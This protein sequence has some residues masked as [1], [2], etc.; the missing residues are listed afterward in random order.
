M[1]EN[2]VAW[3]T[4]F[5][6]DL[7]LAGTSELLSSDGGALAVR[8]YLERT[9]LVRTLA[10]DVRDP[11]QPDLVTRSMEELLLTRLV[12]ICQGWND[13]DDADALRADPGLVHAVGGAALTEGL[14]SQP[15]LSR[16][17]ACLGGNREALSRSLVRSAMQQLDGAEAADGVIVD[18]DS[19]PIVVHGHQDGAEYNGHY[20]DIVFHPLVASIGARRLLLSVQLRPGAVHTATGVEQFT[21]DLL[22]ALREQGLRVN[23]LRFDAGFVAPEYLSRLEAAGIH[24]V[25]RI[26][27]NKV[28]NEMASSLMDEMKL[29]PR[30]DASET[31][32]WCIESTYCAGSW[33]EARRAVL[34]AEHEPSEL[35]VNHF[36]V[37]TSLPKA[38][39]SGPDLLSTYRGRGTAESAFGEFKSVI[40]PRLAHFAETRDKSDSPIRVAFERNEAELLLCAIAFNVLNALRELAQRA[41]GRALSLRTVRERVLKVAVRIVHH[42][43]TVRVT[44]ARAAESVWCALWMT[45]LPLVRG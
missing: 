25:A 36:W 8:E 34:M 32:T 35:F 38:K 15:T 39:L 41:L 37:V 23:L 2:K 21:D 9:G 22:G 19:F 17:G 11:R 18:I 13:Q 29:Q 24:Y 10:T 40:A 33:R 27:N 5:S 6:K 14:A 30:Y 4:S 12:L 44:V 7:R 28:L 3:K 31:V 26:K 42:A 16:L 20:R 1:G 43:R 45:E